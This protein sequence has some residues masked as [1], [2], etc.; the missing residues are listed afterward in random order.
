MAVVTL[1]NISLDIGRTSILRNISL[2]IGPGEKIA[3]LGRSGAGKTS[4]LRIIGSQILPSAGRVTVLKTEPAIM[5]GRAL[6]MLRRRI[7]YVDQD[8][9][10]VPGL[11]VMQNIALARLG[12]T[13]LV[14]GIFSVLFP[15]RGTRMNITELLVEMGLE[16]LSERSPETLSGGQKQRIA[17]ARA[18]HQS[19]DIILADEPTAHVD[20]ER[21]DAMVALLL[22]M[23]SR[24]R[25][26]VPV[27]A[28]MHDVPLAL[29]HFDRVIALENGQVRFDVPA[30]KAV[31][32]LME[33]SGGS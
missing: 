24:D 7:G 33:I 6:R 23:T 20:M 19:P 22:G 32:G 3:L 18:L 28:A 25:S 12:Y 27:V 2:T 10:L 5:R 29:R 13:S 17:L 11:S 14:G 26:N 15:S 8:A 30:A 31:A 16:G 1:D 4:L 21:A 9:V